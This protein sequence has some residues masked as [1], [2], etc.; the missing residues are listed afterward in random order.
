MNLQLALDF[1]SL[2]KSFEITDQVKD[3]VDIIEVGTPLI[4]AEGVGVIK[5]IKERYPQKLIFADMKTADL[6]SLEVRM[7]AE[8]GADIISILGACPIETIE[9]AIRKA[10]ERGDVKIAIDTLG[11]RDIKKRIKELEE[12]DPSY[13]LLHTGID[14]QKV[15]KD[16]LKKIIEFSK[17]TKFPL[18]VGGGID[19]KIA[20]KIKNITNIDIVCVGSAITRADNPKT[21]A[22]E[23]RSIII[24]N[25]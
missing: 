8:E 11:I 21:I 10:W 20:E 6:G 13:M 1:T 18:I 24:E 12:C 25:E 5:K 22:K 19:Q 16:S 2:K 14:E 3:Y 4:K 15:G 7:A 23:I 17:L 9:S